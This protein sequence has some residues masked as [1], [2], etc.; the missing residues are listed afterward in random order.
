[1]EDARRW[2]YAKHN[3]YLG[4][5]GINVVARLPTHLEWKVFKYERYSREHGGGKFNPN[6][7]AE[8]EIAMVLVDEQLSFWPIISFLSPEEARKL[9]EQLLNAS[10][11]K[12]S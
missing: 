11:A 10:R 4:A 9:G 3:I 7:S 1:M 5:Y 12:P 8:G 2:P 6:L